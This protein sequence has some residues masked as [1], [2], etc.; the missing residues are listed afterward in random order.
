MSDAELENEYKIRGEFEDSLIELIAQAEELVRKDELSMNVIV[1]GAYSN[2]NMPVRQHS[3]QTPITVTNE[4]HVKLPAMNLP[5]FSGS[6]EEWPGFSDTFRSAIHENPSYR[7]TQ[8]VIY[9]RSY[10]AGKASEKIESLETTAANYSVAWSILERYYDDPVAIINNRIKALFDL[11]TCQKSSSDA[12]GEIIDAASK[13]Y[14]SLK[15]LN[16][17]FLEAFPIYAIVS[18]LDEQTRLNWKERIQNANQ[19]PSVEELLEF[20]QNCLKILEPL[21]NNISTNNKK[22]ANRDNSQNQNSKQRS[23]K[24]RDS[25]HSTFSYAT[26]GTISCYLCKGE[27]FTQDCEKLT[28]A[29][30]SERSEMIKKAHPCFNCLEPNHLSSECLSS[31]CKEC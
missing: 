20:L 30:V 16:K 23:Q 29:S 22:G 13:H 27:H 26:R 9:L 25:N 5:K 14:H 4:T 12:L 17:P 2:S 1:P 28:N 19:I 7:E 10:L 6:Y 8:K 15:A 3:E 11:P 31:H 18:K 24:K 21:S